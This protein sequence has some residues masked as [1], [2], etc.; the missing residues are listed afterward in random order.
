MLFSKSGSFTLKSQVHSFLSVEPSLKLCLVWSF[1]ASLLPS[2]PTVAFRLR[3]DPTLRSL[4]YLFLTPGMLFSALC[5]TDFLTFRVPRGH[6]SSVRTSQTVRYLPHHSILVIHRATLL[7]FI[8][9]LP[10]SSS[11]TKNVI[12][13]RVVTSLFWTLSP[14]P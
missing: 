3:E 9:C 10:P 7:L 2:A 11:P 12:F 1:L 5:M 4:H 14:G 8:Y 6:H 13:W